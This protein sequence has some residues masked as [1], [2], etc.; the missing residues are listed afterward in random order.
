MRSQRADKDEGHF[1]LKAQRP[2]Q[3]EETQQHPHTHTSLLNLAAEAGLLFP[4]QEEYKPDEFSGP[5]GRSGR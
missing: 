5:S 4:A 1:R 3:E 2:S